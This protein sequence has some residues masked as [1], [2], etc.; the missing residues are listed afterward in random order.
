MQLNLFGSGQLKKH[1]ICLNMESHMAY[2]VVL[3]LAALVLTIFAIW[4]KR[5][6][7]YMPKPYRSRPCQGFMW[8][9]VFPRSSNDEIRIFLHQFAEAFNYRK[10]QKLQVRPEDIILHVYRSK[11]P[12]NF[13]VDGLELEAFALKIERMYG[14]NFT[15]AWS[16]TLTFGDLYTSC[17]LK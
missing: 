10:E 1:R 2:F 7:G 14:I 4:H 9:R 5:Y 17:R 15:A 3:S 12:G 11:Y 16:E 8:K 6:G 13:G